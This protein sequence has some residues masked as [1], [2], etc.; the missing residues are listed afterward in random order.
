MPA[1]QSYTMAKK[2]KLMTAAPI[3]P[4]DFTGAQREF[5][6][7]QD[8]RD[9]YGIKRGSAYN[10]LLDGKIK[11]VLLR[12]RGKKSGIRLFDM[13]SVSDYIRQCQAEQEAA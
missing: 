10:L 7:W 1:G 8:V 13:A 12:V 5:G 11:G 6:R 2:N 9:Q 3:I 4:G